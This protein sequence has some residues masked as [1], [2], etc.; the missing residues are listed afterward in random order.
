VE[1]RKEQRLSRCDRALARA[2]RRVAAA[3]TA[4]VTLSGCGLLGGPSGLQQD[5]PQVMTVTSP[6]FGQEPLPAQYT[7]HGK[8]V[9][10]PVYW[11]GA[12][13][14]TKALALVVDD[15][16]APITPYVY[17]I[18]YNINPDT[19]DIQAGRLP[20]GAQQAQNSKG[21]VG[22][23]PPCPNQRHEYR[24]TVY[25]LNAPLRLPKQPSLTAAWTAIARNA[26]ARGRLNAVVMP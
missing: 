13:Q 25:A 3:V 7:C 2:G 6:S 14:G 9:N 4:A 10:P 5:D 18:V 1:T 11:S 21:T 23:A 16:D 8:G 12:P 17:W 20:P 26:I 15:A 19:P 24:F 22:Y